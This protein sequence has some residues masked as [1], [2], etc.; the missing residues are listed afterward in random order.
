MNA[1]EIL[2]GKP[3]GL[4][5]V[6]FGN[7]FAYLTDEVAFAT[8]KATPRCRQKANGAIPSPL[9]RATPR[10]GAQVIGVAE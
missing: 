4:G 3:I 6:P 1:F 7:E 2:Q 10:S 8:T 5:G 9:D